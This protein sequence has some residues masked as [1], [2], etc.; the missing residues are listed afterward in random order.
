M[1]SLG[2]VYSL[3]SA[4]GNGVTATLV[5]T[6]VDAVSG[7]PVA[8]SGASFGVDFN[9]VPDR[10][11]IVSDAGQ[12]L[13]INVDNGATNVDGG[14]NTAGAATLGVTAAAYTNN[15]AD[16]GTLTLLNVL[17]TTTDQL[18]IQAPPNAGT[19]N[20]LGALRVDA[21]AA[22]AF[23]IFSVIRNNTTLSVSGLAVLA[24]TGADGTTKSALYRVNLASGAVYRVRNGGFG[25]LSVIGLAIPLVQGRD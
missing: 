23:D 22:S 7:Q 9:P 21:G 8:L 13:R 5:S 25:T 14:L 3:A 4:P 10:L 11:R 17:N 18:V 2:G 1:G 20:P 12:N 19:Q 16:P 6:I 15:D 24:T